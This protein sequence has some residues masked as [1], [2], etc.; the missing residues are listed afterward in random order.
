MLVCSIT[1][2]DKSKVK[3]ILST[4]GAY[5]PDQFPVSMPVIEKFIEVS[6]VVQSDNVFDDKE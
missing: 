2:A 3:D 4:I 6:S 1:V 5:Q